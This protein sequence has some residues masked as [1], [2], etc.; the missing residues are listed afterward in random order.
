MDKNTR[1]DTGDDNRATISFPF[2]RMTVQRFR[3]GFPR[4]RWS[5][6][7]KAWIVPGKTGLGAL[8]VGWLER[9]HTPIPSPRKRGETPMNSNQSSVPI[10]RSTV[11]GYDLKP[12]IR[13]ALLK[14]SV[15]SPSPGGTIMPKFGG[16]RLRPMIN[17][18]STGRPLKARPGAVNRKSDG[19]VPKPVGEAMK[20]KGHVDVRTSA[21]DEEF[22]SL[23]KRCH[24]SIALL[25]LRPMVSSLLGRSR[26]NWCTVTRSTTFIPVSTAIMF[27]GSGAC[28]HSTNSFEPGPGRMN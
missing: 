19:S 17:L 11:T 20:K 10:F 18:S 23:P 8:I 28:P 2:D 15:R 24:R 5:D 1:L 14:K 9:P 12:H 26:A 16:C 27:G 6:W 4:A 13:G 22:R 21:G 7:N 3:K 25:Q